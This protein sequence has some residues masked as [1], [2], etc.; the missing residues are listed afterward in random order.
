MIKVLNI[1]PVS[2]LGLE[3]RP[4]SD[5]PSDLM[6]FSIVKGSIVV[7]CALIHTPLFF[8]CVQPCLNHTSSTSGYNK[9]PIKAP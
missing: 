9:Y 1:C 8:Y 2:R 6:C 7:N 5:L 3:M 4:R